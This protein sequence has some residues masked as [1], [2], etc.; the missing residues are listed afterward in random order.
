[1]KTAFYVAIV[2]I[3][4]GFCVS[5]CSHDKDTKATP[6]ESAEEAFAAGH[7]SQA[8]NIA[9]SLMLGSSFDRLNVS[10]L[11]RLSMLFTRLGEIS[12]DEEANTAMA[13][14]ALE[15]AFLLDSDSTASFVRNVP[16][17]DRARVAI[18]TAL[19]TARGDTLIEEP[20]SLIY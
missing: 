17:D 10:E 4:L 12:A 5:S 6:L 7:Y 16:L 1:M 18:V 14:R 8:Q 13:A 19:S 15:A 20:D 11:C 9:D 2:F 3:A